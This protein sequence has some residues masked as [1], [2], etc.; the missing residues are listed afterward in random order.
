TTATSPPLP[1]A[2]TFRS[3]RPHETQA[4]P[5]GTGGIAS[6]SPTAKR[7]GFGFA[8]RFKNIQRKDLR[9]FGSARSHP[10]AFS[11][12][13]P[14]A[15]LR[16]DSVPGDHPSVP[17]DL[18]SPDVPW[19]WTALALLRVPA[20]VVLN[21]L[22][23]AAEFALVAVR[24]TRVEELVKQGVRGASAAELALRTL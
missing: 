8:I 12:L 22:F 19:V 7:P 3:E 13:A 10:S 11:C 17:P 21:G 4:G 6:D 20:L 1:F 18:A 2:P 24:H 5:L 14:P 9:Q 16:K 15:I 23:V